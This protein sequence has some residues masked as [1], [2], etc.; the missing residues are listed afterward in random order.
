[1][2][3][4]LREGYSDGC[5]GCATSHMHSSPSAAPVASK[6]G[7]KGLKSS[8]FTCNDSSMRHVGMCNARRMIARH[9]SQWPMHADFPKQQS[10]KSADVLLNCRNHTCYCYM[11]RYRVLLLHCTVAITHCACVLLHFCQQRI[12]V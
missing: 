7:V 9:S 10:C 2:L 6:F 4:T 11:C 3:R 5:A 12:A 8:P 1:M